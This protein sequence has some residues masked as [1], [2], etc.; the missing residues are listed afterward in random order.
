VLLACGGSDATPTPIIIVVTS[1]ATQSEPVNTEPVNTEPANTEPVNTEAPPPQPDA[2]IEILGATLAHGLSEEMQPVDPGADF[3]PDETIYLSV[4][5]KGRPKEGIVTARFYWHE[6]LIAEAGVD[7]ADVNSGLLFSIGQNT[8]AGYNLNHEQPF[9]LS[10][11]YRVEVFDDQALLGTYPFRVVPPAE[12]IPSQVREAVLALG[13]DENYDPIDPTTTFGFDE[14]VHL[15]AR[16]DLGLSSWIQVD[17]YVD[18][19]LDEAGTRS[20][21]MDENAPETGFAFSFLPEG[22]WPAGEH[23]VILTMD[24]QEVGTYSFTIISSGGAAPLDETAF[25]DAFPLPDDAEIVTVTEGY[26]YG[27]ATSMIEPEVFD[28]YAA[29][30][31]EQGWQQQAPAEATVTL[32]HQTWRK[33][34]AEFLIEI[35]GL[36]EQNWTVVWVNLEVA[37]E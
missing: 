30:L 24:D 1:A 14:T 16:G 8:Y 33:D 31:R 15:V 34:G 23:Y 27:F 10:D 26:D 32:P 11:Q 3:R 35:Q 9:P 2:G 6:D 13:A 22:G 29:W 20:L 28:A 18:G 36:D 19:Q 12:A 5:I 37:T 7:I 4:E 25:W 17:W 21:T